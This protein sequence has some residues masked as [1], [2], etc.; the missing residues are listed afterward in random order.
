MFQNPRGL[1]SG[2]LIS[3]GH[4]YSPWIQ[5]A[6]M[7]LLDIFFCIILFTY[8]LAVLVFI[9]AQLFHSC[10]EQGL[11]SSCVV[12]APHCSGF[13]CCRACT[14]GCAGYSSCGCQALEHRRSSCG[15]QALLLHSRWDLPG[16]GVEPM[17]PTLAGGFFIIEA[18]GK[19]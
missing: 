19:P 16:K 14:L 15:V 8:F 18:P 4:L 5:L 12:Q 2:I 6:R 7:N 10:G 11:L 3:T 17:S 13:S 9:A 1:F